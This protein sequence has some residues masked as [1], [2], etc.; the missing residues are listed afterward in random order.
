MIGIKSKEMAVFLKRAYLGGVIEECVLQTTPEGMHIQAL[1]LTNTLLVSVAAPFEATLNSGSIGISTLDFLIKALG[2]FGDMNIEM[3]VENNRLIMRGQSN[4]L[5]YLLSAAEAVPTMPEDP[6]AF[7]TIKDS[8]VYSVKLDD[9]N[10]GNLA[11]NISLF[12]KPTITVNIAVNGA[13]GVCSVI[14]GAETENQFTV[15]FG[16]VTVAEGA[17]LKPLTF[18]IDANHVK[19]C[20]DATS[21][22]E[23]TPIM[24]MAADSS[25]PVIICQG[26]DMWGFLPAVAVKPAGGE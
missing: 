6:A 2:T 5:K 13:R 9:L 1:D 18:E 16:R 23:G 20:L 3:G 11:T 4:T 14:C 22:G 24:M 19:A 8:L 21:T 12:K 10:K 7:A 25:Y 15:Q 17:E 26:V